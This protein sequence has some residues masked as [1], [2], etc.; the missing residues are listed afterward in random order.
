MYMVSL[1]PSK[2]ITYPNCVSYI[3]HQAKKSMQAGVAVSALNPRAGRQ[4]QGDL[5]EFEAS[6]IYT[7]F[8]D[9]QS[10]IKEAVLT[11]GVGGIKKIK[12]HMT[13]PQNEHLCHYKL[14]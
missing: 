8:Q 10:L 9:S 2:K 11:M 6:L 4:R 3:E 14:L 13:I 12:K 7:E 1:C 5:D